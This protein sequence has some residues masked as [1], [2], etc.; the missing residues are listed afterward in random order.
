MLR[1]VISCSR[2]EGTRYIATI[3]GRGY[4]FVGEVKP[5]EPVSPSGQIAWA[6]EPVKKKL[7]PR[8]SVTLFIL[9]GAFLAGWLLHLKPQAATRS[10]Q[11]PEP[12]TS[13]PGREIFPTF[14]PEGDRV[15]FM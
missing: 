1:K 8:W 6:A 13:Y 2:G 4:Q 3:D 9:V 7:L 14:S 5:A 10:F 15:A 11:R 12:L